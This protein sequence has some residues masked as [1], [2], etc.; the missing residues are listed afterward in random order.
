MTSYLSIAL[1]SPIA[2]HPRKMR[3]P[4]PER[5]LLAIPAG[6]LVA[7]AARC[8]ES[9][10]R[11]DPIRN[12]PPSIYLPGSGVWA[13]SF[14]LCSTHPGWP[15]PHT[16]HLIPLS[17]NHRTCYPP[18][19]A[20]IFWITSLIADLLFRRFP[21]TMALLIHTTICCTLIRR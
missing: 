16:Q 10:A 2:H 5:D 12:W 21:C 17:G 8:K 6:L 13:P 9:L 3:K 7:H 15:L 20:S 11:T 14:Y 18:P 4:N 1:H 19:W